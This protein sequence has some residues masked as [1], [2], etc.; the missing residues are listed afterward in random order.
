MQL[1]VGRQPD[2]V[3][4]GAKMLAHRRDEADF[5]VAV[6]DPHIARRATAIHLSGQQVKAPCQPCLDGL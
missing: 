5:V 1:A 3:A 4:T 2:T 6:A